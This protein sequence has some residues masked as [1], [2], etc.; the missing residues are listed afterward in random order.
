MLSINEAIGLYGLSEK[1]L[2]NWIKSGLLQ[3]REVMVNGR[4][5]HRLDPSDIERL[6]ADRNIS[7]TRRE[8]PVDIASQLANLTR[9]LEELEDFIETLRSPA[10]PHSTTATQ[11]TPT[12][13]KATSAPPERANKAIHNRD[14]LP[15]GAVTLAEFADQ[16][17]VNYYTALTQAKKGIGGKKGIDGKKLP[18][19]ERPKPGREHEIERYLTVEQQGEV[20]AYWRRHRVYFDDPQNKEETDEQV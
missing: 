7:G 1:T 12:A 5:Q 3:T 2:R 19:S 14:G 13:E 16:F 4:N 15:P 11:L 9:R 20:L 10:A 17:G 8:M 6:I 18:V